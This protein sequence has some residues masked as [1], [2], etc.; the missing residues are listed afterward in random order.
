VTAS[1]GQRG[2]PLQRA[3]SLGGGRS[4]DLGRMVRAAIA[5]AV[6]TERGLE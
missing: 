2:Q 4:D 1:G 5:A 6:I 3:S